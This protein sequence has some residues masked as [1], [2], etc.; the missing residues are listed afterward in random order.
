MP[1]PA[2][3]TGTAPACTG[4]ANAHGPDAVRPDPRAHPRARD[5]EQRPDPLAPAPPTSQARALRAGQ[6]VAG[7]TSRTRNRRAVGRSRVP[8]PRVTALRAV[9]VLRFS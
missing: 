9:P 6:C 7:R 1:R 8:T 2:V 3:Q 4:P 5:D